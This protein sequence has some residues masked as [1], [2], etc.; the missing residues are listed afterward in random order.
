MNSV[1]ALWEGMHPLVS[2][3]SRACPTLCMQV[4]ILASLQK[5]KKLTFVGSDGSD[6]SFLAKPKDDLRKDYRQVMWV[7][8]HL[9]YLG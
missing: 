2:E 8:D 7:P 4:L 5:P 6:R 3:P 9:H 1:T